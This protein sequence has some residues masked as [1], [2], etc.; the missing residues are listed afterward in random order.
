MTPARTELDPSLPRTTL[1]QLLWARNLMIACEA[2]VVLLLPIIFAL[3]LPVLPMTAIIGLHALHAGFAH[4]RLRHGGTGAPELFLQLGV[5]AAVLA[6]LVYF[7]GGYANPFI[8]LLLLPLILCAVAL[9]TRYAWAMT[10]WVAAL[11]SLL[12]RYYQPLALEVDSQDAIDLHLAGMWFNFLLTAAMVSA[13]AARLAVALRER[14]AELARARERSL[15]DE[16]LFSLGMQ[17]AAAAHDLATQLSALAVSLGEL[18]RDYAGD[19]ELAP[20]LSVMHAQAERMRGVLDRLALA[21][22][23]ARDHT[24]VSRPVEAWLED[25]LARWQLMWP[26]AQARLALASE[27]PGPAVRDDPILVSVLANLLNNAARVSPA[28]VE[29]RADWD[30]TELHLSVLD[31]GPGMP[32]EADAPSGW[33]VGLA[34]ARAAL[35][36]YGGVLGIDARAGGGTDVSVHLPL[37]A[38]GGTS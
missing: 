14:D 21:A 35:E 29:L 11:Y 4:A 17:A 27:A 7:S 2:G 3:R 13:F 31:R 33:G 8:S 6:A 32:A 34:L 10:V 25:L 38:I 18:R 28:E 12:A 20:A 19:D 9:P 36:R 22:G 16:Q 37:A 24:A 15:R 5:D 1:R 23:A 30:A 26:T